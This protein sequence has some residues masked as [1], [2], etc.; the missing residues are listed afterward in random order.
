MPFTIFSIDRFRLSGGPRLRAVNVALLLEHLRRHFLAPHITRIERRDVHG[1][2]V[3]KLLKFIG[4]RHEIRLAIDF[5]EHTN[6]AARVD[7]TAH[8]P[9][10]GFA[11]RFLCRG[12]LALF[13]QDADGL[14][15]VAFGFHERGAAI[16]ESRAGA[17]AQLFHELRR[18]LNSWLVV[19]SFVFSSALEI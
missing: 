16:A 13:A 3:A 19:C 11:L 9:F 14:F 17:L 12:R 6:L 5:H 2:V 10:A 18:N 8:E 7:V 15:D 1:D 4:A